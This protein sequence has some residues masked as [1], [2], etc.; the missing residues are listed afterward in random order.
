MHVTED[1]VRRGLEHRH[2][3]GPAVHLQDRA[4]WVVV[5]LPL[6]HAVGYRYVTAGFPFSDGQLEA[7]EDRQ[8]R[9]GVGEAGVAHPHRQL[10]AGRQVDPCVVELAAHDA[11]SHLL[12]VHFQLSFEVKTKVWGH[13]VGHLSPYGA[14]DDE[15]DQPAGRRRPQPAVDERAAREGQLRVFDEELGRREVEAAEDD[16]LAGRVLTPRR[17]RH[18]DAQREPP[19]AAHRTADVGAAA[20]PGE[21]QRPIEAQCQ[22]AAQLV[23]TQAGGAPVDEDRV[24]GAGQ[25]QR[26]VEIDA[27]LVLRPAAVVGVRAERRNEPLCAVHSAYNAAP[28]SSVKDALRLGTD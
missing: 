16:A 23:G 12:C 20:V 9:R 24:S 22:A 7:A 21:R 14:F 1:A 6:E 10:A 4:D 27:R 8:V 19:L 15:V 28:H 2:R 17:A 11:A 18:G 3:D 13:L 5:R 26:C 25:Q